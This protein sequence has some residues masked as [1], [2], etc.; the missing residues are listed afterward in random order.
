MAHSAEA[1]MGYCACCLRHRWVLMLSG[2]A[3]ST[4]ALPMGTHWNVVIPWAYLTNS[5]AGSRLGTACTGCRVFAHVVVGTHVLSLTDP[6]TRT[7]SPSAVAGDAQLMCVTRVP[8]LSEGA[9][10]SALHVVRPAA[11]ISNDVARGRGPPSRKA[12]RSMRI[13]M[14]AAGHGQR[15]GVG[16]TCVPRGGLGLRGERGRRTRTRTSEWWSVAAYIDSRQPV[17]RLACCCSGIVVT[18]ERR[19]IIHLHIYILIGGRVS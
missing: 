4:I 17:F 9:R 6:P 15:R 7:A 8:C 2:L 10:P 5:A 11:P 3:G 16:A 12:H 19:S 18:S 14:R 1:H 13:P